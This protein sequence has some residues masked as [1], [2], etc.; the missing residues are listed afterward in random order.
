MQPYKH[1]LS[2]LALFPLAAALVLVASGL[3]TANAHAQPESTVEKIFD[4]RP[5]A[6]SVTVGKKGERARKF[7][8]KKESRDE[9]LTLELEEAGQAASRFVFDAQG[10]A[11][12][13]QF[14]GREL[15]IL[16]RRGSVSIGTTVCRGSD[17]KCIAETVMAAADGM[18][19][20]EVAA[21]LVLLA[22]DLSRL[23]SGKHVSRT[24]EVLAEKL[25]FPTVNL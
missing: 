14:G 9:K 13:L 17:Y 25:A 6:G 1:A 20:E 4:V 18:T 16:I 12:A 19:A 15:E 7:A 3:L 24:L 2:C 8:V 23:E 21:T 10:Q 22:D 5:G 11:V